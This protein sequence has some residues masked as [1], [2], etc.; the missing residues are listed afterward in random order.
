MDTF[1]QIERLKERQTALLAE[2]GQSDDHAAKCAKLG[3]VFKDEYPDDYAAYTAARDEY[4]VNE[5]KLAELQ[6]KF[7]EEQA[8]EIRHEEIGEQTV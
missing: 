2:M 1:Y 5:P 3:L 7:K 4:N 6:A 8:A